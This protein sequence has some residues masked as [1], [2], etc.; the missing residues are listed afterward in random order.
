MTAPHRVLVL[1]GG[2]SAEH[3]ISL[4]SGHGVAGALAQRGFDAR[5]LIIPQ[6]VPLEDAAAWT[7]VA[8]LRERGD[9]VFIA[10]H[11]VFGEDGSIQQLC[12]ELHL[13]YT[14]SG[15]AASRLGMDKLASR[16]RF[17]EA[18]LQVP[19]WRALPAG[20]TDA[21]SLQGLRYPLIVKPS[22]QGSSIG[23]TKV[24]RPAE[25]G[26]ALQEAGRYGAVT[27]VEEFIE[28]REL[29]VGVLGAR[30][31]PV[32][33]IAPK[34]SWFDFT[35]KYT[36]GMTEYH[37]PAALDEAVARHI[38]DIGLRAHQ[39]VGC[40][41]MSRAD[42]LLAAEQEPVLL[43]V[44]TIPGFTPTSLLPKAAGAMGVTYDELCER[45]VL[46][47]WEDATPGAAGTRAKSMT[48]AAGT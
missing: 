11:G 46:M 20:C 41:H 9:I 5:P 22:N 39:V 26:A 29:T 45:L 32:I 33:E 17:S 10:L 8:L 18:G 1:M 19:R 48:A 47:A 24:T 13:A 30:A 4:K 31:L 40:R 27:L 44:N 3:A 6:D 37:V 36:Q 16:Q 15:P 12:E 7:R 2:P 14:G 35:A 38:Q 21:A 25:L 28:G 42:I 43:E 23:I 34:Q